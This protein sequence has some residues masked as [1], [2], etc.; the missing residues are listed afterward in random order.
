[1]VAETVYRQYNLLFI[2]FFQFV[3]G[4]ELKGAENVE[5]TD[6]LT[7]M[8]G[9][10][11]MNMDE[12]YGGPVSDPNVQKAIRKALDYSGIRMICGEGTVTPYSI[13]QEGFMG[14]KGDRPD[15]YTTTLFRSGWIQRRYDRI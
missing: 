5:I 2:H 10:V 15:D 11:M 7:K 8:I 3:L 1:M 12:Q 6:G 4:H 9:F 13:I 14:S